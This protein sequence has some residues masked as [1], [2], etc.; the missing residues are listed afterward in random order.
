MMRIGLKR[1][2]IEV[3]WILSSLLVL[4]SQEGTTSWEQVQIPKIISIEPDGTDIAKLV[5]SFEADISIQGADKANVF[6]MDEKGSIIDF[7]TV[8]RTVRSIKKI[9]FHPTKSGIYQFQVALYRKGEEEAKRSTIVQYSF[10]LPMILPEIKI[11]NQGKGALLIQWP[12]VSEAETYEICYTEVTDKYNLMNIAYE[13]TDKSDRIPSRSGTNEWI[14]QGLQTGKKYAIALAASRGAE[15]VISSP[16]IKTVRDIKERDWNFV[17]FGQST[18]ESLNTFKMIDN[19]SFVFQLGSCSYNYKTGEIIQKGGKFTAFHDGISFYY[20]TIDPRKE[21]FE[22]TATFVVDYINPT[23]D[24]QEGFGLLALDSLG[25]NGVN[26]VNHYTNSAGIIA[27]KFEETIDGIK[28]T[29]KD[30]LGARFVTG[31]TKDVIALG[32][33]GIA[34]YGVSLGRAFSYDQSAQIKTGDI[35]RITLKKTNTGYHAV[36]HKEYATEEDRTEF[37]LYGPEKLQ[38]LDPDHIYVGFAVARGCNVT[39][40]D[41]EFKIS[42]VATD[43]KG[44]PEPPEIIPLIAK[45][46]SPSTYTNDRYPLVFNVNANGHLTILNSK[47]TVLIRDALIRNLQDFTAVL[48][49]N[50]GSNDFLLQFTPDSDYKP[51][52]GKVIGR[53]DSEQRT[54][55]KNY[56][57]YYINLSVLY[58]TYEGKELI[59][60][61]DGSPFGKGTY[62]EP[63]DLMT[64]LYFVSPGQ[65]VI[66]KGGIYYPRTSIE[67][68]RGNDGTSKQQKVL[69]AAP[70]ERVVLDFRNS[71]AKSAGFMLWGSY[72]IIEGID[73]RNTPGDVKGLQIGGNYNIIK[74]VATYNCGDTGL[75]ISGISTEPKEKWPRYNQI[76]NCLSH[77][78]KDP[79]SNNA[80]GFAAKLTVGEGNKFYGCIS[81]NN[82][83]DGWDLFSKIE[84]GPIGAVL[85]ENC[86]AYNNGFLSDG[87]GN[88]DGNGFKMGG[89]GIAVPHIIRNSISFGNGA[90]GI[91][92]NSNPALIIESCTSYANKGAN[93]NLYGKGNGKRTFEVQNVISMNGG[94]GDIYHEMPELASQNNYFW[95]GA[96][97]INSEGKQ[98]SLNA[99]ISTEL[100]DAPAW[101]PSGNLDL[102]GYL[103]PTKEVPAGVGAR[104]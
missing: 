73:I 46:D 92:S 59:V 52:P 99:F 85:I 66:L 20:T 55:V 26:S 33:A 90:S 75:Q 72:W 4:Y 77:D 102:D 14:I 37:I 94:T 5:V 21:N 97:S 34:Q 104:F 98:L 27:T 17:W 36:Y 28:R 56:N 32:D 91:T 16:V 57:P 19:D 60:T 74:N 79:A 8:G 45:V 81:H 69:K 86:I 76:I 39:V 31:I 48:K 89:D 58:H 70:G 30:T 7:K 100:R 24:G 18:N 38:N 25:Q 78:N 6:M 42:D 29:G 51:G 96:V 41:V 83:D 40:K 101:G 3:I 13:T 53:Y 80:D 1:L 68:A 22:L 95:N 71:N 47:G 63:L 65:S 23:A 50:R 49:L 15:T 43:P 10:K 11:T 12:S 103:L 2:I 84:S 54:Y 44:I 9:D 88:G 82:I 64:A 61:P 62:K 87:S 35:Y 93:L 67:I